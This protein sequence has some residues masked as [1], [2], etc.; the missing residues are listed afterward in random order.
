MFE[1]RPGVVALVLAVIFPLAVEIGFRLERI[2]ARR[3]PQEHVEGAG[4][5]V[6]AIIGLLGLL[7]GFTFSLASERF[8]TRRSLVVEEANA[9][10]T[11]WLRQQMLADPWRSRLVI[12]MRDY[13]RARQQF[14]VTDPG[15][16]DQLDMRTDALQRQIWQET[17][18][19]LRTPAGA[20]LTLA[21]MQTTNQMF[22]LAAARQAAN[23]A[24]VPFEVMLMLVVFAVVAAMVMG[25]ALAMSGNRYTLVSTGVF[26]LAA[27][28]IGMILDLDEPG[29][30]G[31][32][33]PQA[34]F[35]RV[36][37][38]IVQAPPHP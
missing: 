22:D 36:A 12:L 38:D 3:H 20:P 17:T 10:S 26:V 23:E 14:A 16:L 15:S 4:Y 28:A 8:D 25:Y 5:T 11:T 13:V 30:G 6:S 31:I 34:A 32:R 1:I 27:L 29:K 7:I 2:I 33:V 37:A 21:L 35:D 24:K 9:V 19:A 18:A